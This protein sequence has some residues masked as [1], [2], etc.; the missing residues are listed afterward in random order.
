MSI[1]K[2]SGESTYDVEARRGKTTHESAAERRLLKMA[3]TDTN[4]NTRPGRGENNKR[5]DGPRR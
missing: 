5:G 4:K 1:I 3:G 2:R